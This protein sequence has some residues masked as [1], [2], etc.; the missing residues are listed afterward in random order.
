MVFPSWLLSFCNGCM[1][2]AGLCRLPVKTRT[3]L[4]ADHRQ[5]DPP[6]SLVYS[7]SDWNMTTWPC[8]ENTAR[9]CCSVWLCGNSCHNRQYR[10]IEMEYSLET[11]LHKR[12]SV[13]QC[14]PAVWLTLSSPAECPLNGTSTT[15]WFQSV[16]CVACYKP[17][18]YDT[19]WC[20]RQLC[21]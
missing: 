6:L 18:A 1:L 7:D 10:T 13:L 21:S 16:T 11:S 14:S 20:S 8:R 19:Y 2:F 17:S 12:R 4:A 5:A 9:S 15:R 3:C